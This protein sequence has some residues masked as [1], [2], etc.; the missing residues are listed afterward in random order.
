MRWALG[1]EYDGTAFSGWQAQANA[2]SVQAVVEDAVSAVADQRIQVVAAGRT[3]SGVHALGQVVHFDSEAPRSLR[4]WVLGTNS[5]LP[6]DASVLWA[7]QVPD[8]FHA[9][10]SALDRSYRYVILNR[11]VRSG[12]M[13][14]RAHWELR[15]LDAS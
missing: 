13:R 12:L 2:R 4:S 8:E 7:R 11:S 6:P 5:R 3:D 1:I 9:R 15:P 10:F 14:D